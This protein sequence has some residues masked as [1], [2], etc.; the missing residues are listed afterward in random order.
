MSHHNLA[1]EQAEELDLEE[2]LAEH[3]IHDLYALEG[4]PGDEMDDQDWSDVIDETYY[5]LG[6]VLERKLPK[7]LRNDL[8]RLYNQLETMLE[9][10]EAH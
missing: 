9:T 4:I 5:L 10:Y 8:S 7:G 6:Q 2:L 3:D 1:E